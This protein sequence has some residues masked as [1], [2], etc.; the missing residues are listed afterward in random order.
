[1]KQRFGALLCLAL[2]AVLITTG[3]HA[4]TDAAAG[5][6][7]PT[8]QIPVGV[9]LSCPTGT[10]TVHETT[11][12]PADGTIPPGGWIVH[13]TSTTCTRPNGSSVNETLTIPD[14]GSDHTGQL[15]IFADPGHAAS[16]TYVLTEDPVVGAT[17]VFN[18]TSPVTIPFSVDIHTRNVL[19]TNTFTPVTTTVTPTP[20]TSA[21]TSVSPSVSASSTVIIDTLPPVSPTAPIANTG[22]HEQIRSS[23]YIGIALCLLG[24]G[25]LLAGT[26]QRRRGRHTG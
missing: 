19:V 16:C 23:V 2:G 18:P 4:G 21:P 20:T 13:V 3:L 14:G 10:I 17:A 7:A 6:T 25:L 15:F 24:V 8:C 22:P 11:V 26:I 5:A 12:N 9:S 1:M